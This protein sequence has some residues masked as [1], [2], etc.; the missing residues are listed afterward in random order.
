[1]RAPRLSFSSLASCALAITILSVGP[2]AFGGTESL[3]EETLA[4]LP[5]PVSNNAVAMIADDDGYHL[6]SMLG[7]KAGKSRRDTSSAV[8]HF[9]SAAGNWQRLDSVPGNAGRL[10]ASAVVV[11]DELYLFGG[12]TVDGDGSER[13]TPTVYRLHRESGQWQPFAEMPVAVEDSVLLVYQDRYIYLVSGWHD[14]GNVNLVQVLDTE[15]GT[16][17]QATP[18]PGNPVF[19][20][21]GGISGNRFLICDGV[22]IQYTAGAQARKFLP[23]SD[24]WLGQISSGDFRRVDWQPVAPHPGLPRYR[25][26]AGDDGVGR[27]IFAGGSV[28]PYNFN[29]I[30]YNGIPSKP[31]SAVF[32]YNVKELSWEC[33]GHLSI[34]TMDHRGLPRYEGWFYIIGGMRRGQQVSAGVMRFK[35]GTGS[36]CRE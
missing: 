23:A 27:I 35:P 33:H 30:A 4:D 20:H 24:C 3:L 31:E 19:G 13:S 10:A 34:A 26:A 14:L 36:P 12:Y 21:S 9:S 6:Y 28:N 29:G 17:Q 1:M 7:L 22:R 18:Y 5:E 16:W 25:M 11:A 15:S 32:S 8:M 2:M